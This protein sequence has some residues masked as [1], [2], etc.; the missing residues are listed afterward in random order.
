M[1][2]RLNEVVVH[3]SESIDDDTLD[4]LEDAIRGD[5]GVVAVGRRPEH[6]HL[7][8][9]VYDTEVARAACL[10]QTFQGRGLHAQLVGM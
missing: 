6:T 4:A 3:I 5:C 1:S 8:M 7:M 2:A 9:V 10:L